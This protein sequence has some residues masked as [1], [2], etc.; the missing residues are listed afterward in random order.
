MKSST[1]TNPIQAIIPFQCLFLAAGLLLGTRAAYGY[2]WQAVSPSS[3]YWYGNQSGCQPQCSG[4]CFYTQ[5]EFGDQCGSGCACCGRYTYST[6]LNYWNS[7]GATCVP[8]SGGCSCTGDLVWGGYYN[9]T[10]AATTSDC[11]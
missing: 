7:S 5:Y 6:S 9:G 4:S 3:P 11:G 1:R 10:S 8:D 2:F